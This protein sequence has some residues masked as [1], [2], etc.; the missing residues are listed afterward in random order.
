M[1]S[2]AFKYIIYALLPI[3]LFIMFFTYNNSSFLGSKAGAST[4]DI[5]YNTLTFY[6]DNNHLI[7]SWQVP[8]GQNI[9]NTEIIT[10]YQDMVIDCLP[11]TQDATNGLSGTAQVYN[12]TY[13]FT[14]DKSI[15]SYN[16]NAKRFY[17]TKNQYSSL[18][19]DFGLPD[20]H[21]SGIYDIKFG[22]LMPNF[23]YP[24]IISYSAGEVDLYS[25]YRPTNS[26][27][28]YYTIF[29]F[30]NNYNYISSY[31]VT[32]DVSFIRDYEPYSLTIT[33]IP[34]FI[35]NTTYYYYFGITGIIDTTAS[36][37]TNQHFSFFYDT[38][39]NDLTYTYQ[40]PDLWPLVDL[41]NE[42]ISVAVTNGYLV[43]YPN[44]TYG[45][46]I[47]DNF[48]TDFT[49]DT[50]IYTDT[51]VYY[52]KKTK[53]FAPFNTWQDT[54]SNYAQNTYFTPI[55]IQ[56]IKNL[57]NN[58][59]SLVYGGFWQTIASSLIAIT[60]IFRIVVAC[61]LLIISPLVDVVILVANT[62]TQF[63]SKWFY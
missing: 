49:F 17:S 54:F 42:A 59:M 21:G 24:S 40:E 60:Y 38:Y 37:S 48:C 6:G 9:N 41:V 63:T 26:F 22:Y 33:N 35:Y 57:I 5:D 1:M 19:Y 3:M 25:S 28:L 55:V 12:N 32:E 36:T 62:V 50:N 8:S 4:I 2:K 27:E 44:S 47:R 11:D 13:T 18:Y 15:F 31:I 10:G 39:Y 14:E 23:T 45:W 56:H 51:N 53:L 61:G 58:Y 30:D 34:N 46:S 16:G 20:F 29:A 52:V 7:G 43:Q